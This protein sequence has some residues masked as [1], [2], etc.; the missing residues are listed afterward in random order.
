MARKTL[1][2]MVSAI[3][4]KSEAL[5]VTRGEHGSSIVTAAERFDVPAVP[6]HRI[7]D[8][9]GVGDA[10]RAG[11]VCGMR[12]GI[13]WDVAGRMGSVAAAL[14]LE[15]V[16]PQP[17]AYDVEDFISRY[18]RGF[19]PEPRLERIRARSGAG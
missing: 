2:P 15:A 11:L 13:P 16:G 17:P 4:A 1:P 19:G 12:R 18:E 9:T 6:P 3:L 14:G 5:I 10:F 7:V 8:P